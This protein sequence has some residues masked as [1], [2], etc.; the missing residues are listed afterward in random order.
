MKV[1][2]FKYLR[3]TFQRWGQYRL[4]G[5]VYKMVVRPAMMYGIETAKRRGGAG[6]GRDKDAQVSL[7][8]YYL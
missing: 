4:K 8:V 3:S 6:G 7:D 1:D 5:K 2:K